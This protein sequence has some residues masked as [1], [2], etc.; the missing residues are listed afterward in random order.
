MFSDMRAFSGLAVDDV[1]R[2]RAVY[3]DALGLAAL[4]VDV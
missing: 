2:A 4:E 3:G 1:E